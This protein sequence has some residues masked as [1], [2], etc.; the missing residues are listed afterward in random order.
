MS[1]RALQPVR[2]AVCLAVCLAAD[3]RRNHGDED[4]KEQDSNTQQKNQL[5]RGHRHWMVRQLLSASF[6]NTVS[7][8]A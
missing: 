6:K 8:L 1:N 4:C 2:Y 7:S 5:P 3:L